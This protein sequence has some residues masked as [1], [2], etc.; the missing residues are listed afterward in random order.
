MKIRTGFVSNSSSSS[1]MCLGV[2]CDS[3]INKLL[4]AEKL[5]RNS[6]GY[7]DDCD[8]GILEGKVIT[9][10]GNGDGFFA[11]GIDENPTKEILEQ[12]ALPAA[13]QMFVN[14]IKSKFNIDIKIED[15]DLIWGE[16]SSD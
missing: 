8:S 11:A 2:G 15:V 16:C 5:E 4:K 13:R 10:Y 9:F 12:M 14:K 6:D 3:L 7:Y 1:F